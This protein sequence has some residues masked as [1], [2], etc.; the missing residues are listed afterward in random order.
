MQFRHYW[1][2]DSTPFDACSI[3]EVPNRPADFPNGIESPQRDLLDWATD[4]CTPVETPSS[5][6]GWPQRITLQALT[7]TE[8]VA[9]AHLNVQHGENIHQEDYTLVLSSAPGHWKV[10][11]VH[12]W[13]MRLAGRFRPPPK[14]TPLPAPK[15]IP[16]PTTKPRR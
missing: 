9:Y 10:Q 1:M 2:R 4:P 5:S 12:V 8:W 3:Y 6:M 13:G 7:I 16:V 14:P 15:P 11:D